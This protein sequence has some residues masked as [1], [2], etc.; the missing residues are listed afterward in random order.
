MKICKKGFKDKHS[1]E[2]SPSV[3]CDDCE[4]IK[5]CS[6]IYYKQKYGEKKGLKV[7]K[8]IYL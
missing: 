6:R 7:F 4:Y 2:Q 3:L 1:I 5:R 8:Y